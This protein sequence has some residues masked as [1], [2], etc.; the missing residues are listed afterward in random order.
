MWFSTWNGLCRYDGYEFR[1]FKSRVGD[2]CNM[3]T[4]RFRDIALRP[5]GK[6]LC[7]VDDDYYLFDTRTYRFS[8]MT[9][10][11]VSHAA[12]EIKQY[13]KSIGLKSAGNTIN[14][15]YDDAQVK[16]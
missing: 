9:A 13:R 11:E 4:D 15:A 10:E 5:D 8:N 1:T 12:D 2:G 16:V 14:F 6:M 3:A 7:R